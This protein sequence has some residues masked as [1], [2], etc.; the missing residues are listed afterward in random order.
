MTSSG[1]TAV[2]LEGCNRLWCCL[3]ELF[4]RKAEK[5][6]R[7]NQGEPR[8]DLIE[9]SA[10]K[11][12]PTAAR[13]HAALVQPI[14]PAHFGTRQLSV[15]QLGDCEAVEI[16]DWQLIRVLWKRACDEFRGLPD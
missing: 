6:L 13:K 4:L 16:P 15:A 5:L 11:L 8:V 1:A 9:Q 3:A 14:A 2:E 12:P 10:D 7:Q